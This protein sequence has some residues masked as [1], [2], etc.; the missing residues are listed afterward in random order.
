MVAG[1]GIWA[2]AAFTEPSTTPGNS[3]QDFAKNIM[4]ANNSDNAFDSGNVVAN[5]DGSIVE[6]LE[7]QVGA[8]ALSAES[9]ATMAIGAVAAYCRD[10]SATA[11]Y[12]INES[13]TSAIYTD[14]RLGSLPELTNFLG[15]T[16][17]GNLICSPTAAEA[18]YSAK[19][20]WRCIRLSDG[21]IYNYLYNATKYVRCVR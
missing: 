3:V 15:M 4:G 21:Y 12:A 10:L 11:E 7:A 16:A 9:G 19:N 20:A 17:S 18:N 8:T 1:T 6:G 5:S 2:L 13:N 14:W